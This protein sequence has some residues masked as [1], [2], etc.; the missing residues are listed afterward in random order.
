[1]ARRSVMV[2]AASGLSRQ[3][4]GP[5]RKGPDVSAPVSLLTAD[6]IPPVTVINPEGR[7]AFLIVS[8][9]A[10][11]RLPRSVGTLGLPAVDR[12]RHIAWDIGIAGVCHALSELLD[13]TLIQQNYSRLLIDCNRPLGV[14][15][16]IPAESDASPVPGNQGIGAAERQAREAGIFLPYHARIAA[17]LDRRQAAGA[18]AILLAMHSFT[19][20]FA[21]FV[22]PW[23][24]GLLYHRDSRFAPGAPPPAARRWR[25]HG[26]R[27]RAVCGERGD[28]PGPSRSTASGAA[29]PMW[30]SRS[31][32]IS[33]AGRKASGNGPSGSRRCSSPLPRGSRRRGELGADR[34]ALLQD[35]P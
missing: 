23:H 2:R 8:D 29:F 31:G 34:T 5:C 26:G 10:G 27:Q 1:M 25:A 12:E 20:V 18:P 21:G 33:S 28:G 32:R 22:R 16:S 3:V 14:A 15:Q 9:H 35:L 13:A 17:E 4:R 24:A 11:N 19:P 7:S 6:D 30:A